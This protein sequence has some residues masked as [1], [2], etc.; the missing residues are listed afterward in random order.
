MIG[1]IFMREIV[2]EFNTLGAYETKDSTVFGEDNELKIIVKPHN[3]SLKVG[4]E[5]L[6]E[7]SESGYSII[8]SSLGEAVLYDEDGKEIAKAAPGDTQYC[9]VRLFW[10]S[11]VFSL[12]FG[13]VETVDNYPNCDGEYDRWSEQW[14]KG[15]EVSF[16]SATK[17]MK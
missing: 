17:E 6:R 3:F 16:I 9:E 13:R 4:D 11:G 14:V 7:S 1:G 12:Q 10:N 15:R 2:Y 8:V 5:V